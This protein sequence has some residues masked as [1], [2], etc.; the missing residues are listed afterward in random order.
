MPASKFP[1]KTRSRLLTY[2]FVKPAVML[3]TRKS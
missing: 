3:S 2:I 1:E